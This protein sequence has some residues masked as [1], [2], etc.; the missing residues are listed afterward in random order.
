MRLKR[1]KPRLG[2]KL[3]IGPVHLKSECLLTI[4]IKD[5]ACDSKSSL[6]TLLHP[7]RRWRIALLLLR[8]F[9]GLGPIDLPSVL[10]NNY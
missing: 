6:L 2:L 3:L 1:I 4:L 7:N 5:S 9:R 10:I 8:A